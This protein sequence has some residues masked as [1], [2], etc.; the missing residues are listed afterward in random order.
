V[1]SK[2]RR[3]GDEDNMDMAILR[4]KGCCNAAGLFVPLLSNHRKK[5]VISMYE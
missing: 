3:V 1:A 5:P 2:L 4:V